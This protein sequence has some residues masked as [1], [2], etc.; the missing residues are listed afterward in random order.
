MLTFLFRRLIVLVLALLVVSILAFLIPYLSGPEP[1]QMI[2]HARVSDLAI[3]P[4]T[5][6]ALRVQLGL[7]RPL[8]VQ[9]LDWLGKAV[10][11]DFGFTFTDRLPVSLHIKHA[12][13][14]SITL[15]LSALI[16]ALSVALPLGA[17]AALKPAGRLDNAITF[18]TQV[19]VAIPE[20][21]IAPM[22]ALVFAVYLQWL[23]SAGWTGPEHIILPALALALR[24]MAYFTRVMRASM[25]DVLEAP[26]ITA[27]L[28]RGLGWGQTIQRHGIR[29]AM[30]PVITLF[31][32]WLSG[33]IG[34]AVVIE[35]IFSIPGMG[36]LLYEAVVNKDLPVLQGTIMCLVSFAVLMSTITDFIYVLINP[37]VRIKDASG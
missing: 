13:I 21:W 9:Y 3:D 1:A 26:Y 33:L 36:R 10:R 29:N 11:G 8:A 22:A 28:S 30:T 7:D 16:L 23:P 20:Y 12:F 35:V 31:A 15:A 34:G 14:V 4:D 37:A 17:V 25:I 24:P 18:L 19:L 6:A 2:M 5:I 27:A 32:M